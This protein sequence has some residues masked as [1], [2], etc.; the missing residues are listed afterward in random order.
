VGIE[1]VCAGFD[2]VSIC[3]S[4]G[5]G[6]PVGSVLLGDREFLAEAHRYR[7]LMGGG[8]RQAG[9]LAAAGIHALE[10]MPQRL[11]EDHARARRLAEALAGLD[12][13]ALDLEA[14][15]TNMVYLELADA[16]AYV[17]RCAAHGVRFNAVGARRARLVLHHQIDDEALVR[18]IAVL[19]AQVRPGVA[20]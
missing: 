4:K 11:A 17:E 10:T 19:R 3:L 20:A 13:I 16:P 18:A 15:Q 12:G 2:S 8:M 1:D 7:K 14:V 9:I 5:L 6:A